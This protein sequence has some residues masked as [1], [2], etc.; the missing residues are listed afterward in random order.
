MFVTCKS[1]LTL[2]GLEKMKI[3]AG[4]SGLNKV[5]NWVHVI[6]VPEVVDW[7]KGG[8]LLFITG[9]AIKDNT[10][11]LLKLVRDINDRNLSGLVINV[12]PYIK[13]TPK[14]VIDLAN[15]I[16]FPIFELPFE[17]K[18]I[19]VTQT[20]CR[21]IFTKK[22]QKES[23]NN[24]MKEIIFDDINITEETLVRASLYGYSKNI[25][26]CSLVV[27]IDNFASYLKSKKLYDEEIILNIKI[28][29]QEIIDH[30]MYKNNKKYLYAIQS[31]A[32]FLMV[33]LEENDVAIKDIEYIADCI[34]EDI[35]E[36]L[37]A[38]TASI[39]IGGICDNLKNFKKAI[40]EARKALEITKHC[41]KKDCIVNYRD[42][43]IYR[44]F[45]EMNTYKEMKNLYD[46]TLLRL[47]E[48]DEK[49]STNL[50]ETLIMYLEENRNLGKTAEKLYI[51]RNTIKYRV[52]RIE[53][54]LVCDLKDDKTVFDIM[55]SIKAG[56]FLKLI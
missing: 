48:Y 32:F 12:G 24:F 23:M 26:Y 42:L 5:I 10:K 33:P 9:V 28:R 46:E 4:K 16:N 51:H 17:V 52:K 7:V 19:D 1:I 54:I 55:L 41:G 44:L 3:V 30:I 2:P 20:I 15:D 14:E 6:E 47:K 56:V 8:E 45:F 50:L 27:D 38:I 13:E 29:I 40:F 21:R 53:E 35:S 31:D 36:K 49:N 18:L 39:G 22:L 37:E 11:A 43:G 25:T 34:K